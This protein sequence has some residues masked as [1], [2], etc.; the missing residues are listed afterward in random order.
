MGTMS[1]HNL[2]ELYIHQL[3]DLHSA[4]KQLIKAL[5]KVAEHANNQALRAAIQNHLE[6][7]KGHMTRLEQIMDAEGV[8]PGR[9]LCKGMKG[10][11]EE[12]DEVMKNGW[13]EDTLDAGI[14]SAAQKVEHYEIS[15]YGTARAFAE[16]LGKRNA[17]PLLDA[18]L[19]EEKAADRKLT[20][21]A[22]SAVNV[23]ATR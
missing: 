13:D 6:E 4:E 1:K 19:D 22:E 9:T 14:I 23:R 2:E 8:R 12:S 10:L 7:T 11:I 16:R 18:T 3:K 17:V 20:Q 5:P 15:G 21:I